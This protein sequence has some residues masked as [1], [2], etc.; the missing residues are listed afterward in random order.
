MT[1]PHASNA[2]AYLDIGGLVIF[3]DTD[4]VAAEIMTSAFEGPASGAP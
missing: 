4:D 3:H 2:L 1:F